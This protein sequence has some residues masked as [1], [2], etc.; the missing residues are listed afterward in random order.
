MTN[1]F[2]TVQQHQKRQY[3]LRASITANCF[4][5]YVARAKFKTLLTTAVAAQ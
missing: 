4:V 3:N 5:H 2:P 1:E